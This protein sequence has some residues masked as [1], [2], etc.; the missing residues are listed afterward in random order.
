MLYYRAKH[1]AYDYL[2]KNAVVS[3]ELLTKRERETRVP[4]LQ[5]C[6][7]DIVTISRRNTFI[8]FGVRFEKKGK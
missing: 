6:L 8:N 7:F 1:D 5:D 2:T 4:Y 3:N